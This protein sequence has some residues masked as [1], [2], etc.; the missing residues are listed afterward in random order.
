M[1]LTNKVY[2][3]LHLITEIPMH[4]CLSLSSHD[5]QNIYPHDT[6]HSRMD[7]FCFLRVSEWLREGWT[8]REGGGH[9]G[10]VRK[11]GS[12]DGVLGMLVGVHRQKGFVCGGIQSICMQDCIHMFMYTP[13]T[14]SQ[15]IMPVRPQPTYHLN[16]HITYH[17]Y[18]G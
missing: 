3:L 10:G 15:N 8:C 4:P 13:R 7:P 2:L 17:R 16:P 6:P 18:V 5:T 14:I 11:G 12:L 1:P 9:A